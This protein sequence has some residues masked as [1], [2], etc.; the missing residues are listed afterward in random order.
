[1]VDDKKTE[2]AMASERRAQ[3]L[4][5]AHIVE[6]GISGK[7]MRARAVEEQITDI[8][9]ELVDRQRRREGQEP[10]SFARTMNEKMILALISQRKK[11][12]KEFLWS[13]GI[14]TDHATG[15]ATSEKKA[16]DRGVSDDEIDLARTHPIENMIDVKRG[17]TQC[18]SG[19]HADKHPSMDV[20][21]N[22]AHCYAC[23]WH[24]DA[25][26]I[27]MKVYGLSFQDAVRRLQ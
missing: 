18:I 5:Q 27:A 21:N 22:F 26:A 1:M 14:L 3:G 17:M 11:L 15:Y 13:L 4:I 12:V 20:R 6:V 25:I 7:L 16:K 19:N 10:K 8:E 9:N 23:G 24:G 2:E